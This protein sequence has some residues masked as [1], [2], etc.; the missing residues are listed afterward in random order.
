MV[1]RTVAKAV[2]LAA[3]LI[4]AKAVLL[5]RNNRFGPSKVIKPLGSGHWH[6]HKTGQGSTALAAVKRVMMCPT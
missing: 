1:A 5:C 2:L 6:G 4:V 3:L